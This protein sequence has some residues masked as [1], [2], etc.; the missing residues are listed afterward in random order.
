MSTTTSVNMKNKK[1]SICFKE[2]P[3]E[4]FAI[5][6]KGKFGRHAR[7]KKCSSEYDKLYNEINR[8]KRMKYKAEYR[9]NNKEKIK[10]YNESVKDKQKQYYINNA[11]RMKE[12]RKNY[13]QDNK[14]KIKKLR[15]NDNFIRMKYLFSA[16]KCRAKNKKRDFELTPEF[17][18]KL[19][20]KQ[21]CKCAYTG[22]NF[23]MK[24]SLENRR[25]AFGPSIDRIDS[26][27]GYMKTNVQLV[28]NMV[29]MAKSEFTISE[30]DKMCISR[31]EKLNGIKI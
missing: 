29:N 2:L 27:K 30:F 26:K 8:E 28:C 16:A 24:F 25:N 6:K 15:E 14:I 9:K 19:L 23:D 20:N 4:H 11:D 18:L 1:C 12:Y 3:L 21:K 22:L 10:I 31:M 7:C 13:H 5:H 17:L